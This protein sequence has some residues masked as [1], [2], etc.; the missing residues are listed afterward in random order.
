[1]AAPA[2]V[3]GTG[4][5][6]VFAPTPDHSQRLLRDL[7]RNRRGV[8]PGLSIQWHTDTIGGIMGGQIGQLTFQEEM[9]C[10]A[11]VEEG[12]S[13]VGAYRICYPSRR[14]PRSA[15]AERT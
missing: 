2:S 11:V 14:G 8:S 13:L 3:V 5:T 12:R 9:F 1:M 6:L 10:R 7:R 4:P 15:G